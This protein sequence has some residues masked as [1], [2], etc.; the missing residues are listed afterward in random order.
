[1]LK[2]SVS[3][4]AGL[5]VVLSNTTTPGVCNRRLRVKVSVLHNS[6]Q[7]QITRIEH[8]GHTFVSAGVHQKTQYAR[9]TS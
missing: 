5:C 9:K 8:T 1:M 2:S 6:A 4:F 7:T 3:N